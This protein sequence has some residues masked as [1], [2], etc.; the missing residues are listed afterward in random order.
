MKKNRVLRLGL[1]ALALTLVTASLVSG[2]FAKY[3]TTHTGT[4]TVSV[5]K[6]NASLTTT[7][8]ANPAAYE[9]TVTFDL[10]D[11]NSDD[12]IADKDLI[13]PGS[14]GSYS[15]TYDTAGTQVDHSI[16][17]TL[18]QIAGTNLKDATNGVNNLELKVG[19]VV[20]TAAD[21]TDGKVVA[22]QTVDATAGGATGTHAFTW[23]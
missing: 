6:W 22:E 14:S 20:L 1:L 17:V 11:N 3:A 15:F 21:L 4:E 10:F 19:E 5:A 7:D 12:G 23:N 2:T 8:G 18:K 16:S 13:A 9:N